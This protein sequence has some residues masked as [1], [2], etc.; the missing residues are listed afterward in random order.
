MPTIQKSTNS[1]NI[2]L[3]IPES[4][5]VGWGKVFSTTF[6]VDEVHDEKKPYRL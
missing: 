6:C 4:K 2:E 1:H 3:W 5:C